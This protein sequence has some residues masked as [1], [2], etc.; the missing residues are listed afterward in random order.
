MPELSEDF[1]R[2]P[3]AHRG[4]HERSRGAVENSRAAVAAAVAAGYAIEIDVQ[5]ASCG[6]PMVF[7]D[8]EL[9]RLT[10]ARGRL[11]ARPAEELTEIALLD[12]GETIP[13]LAEILGLVNGRAPL[14]VE[15]KDQTGT[16]G[17][18]VGPLEERVAALLTGYDGPLAVMSFNPHSVDAM[19]RAAPQVA[20]GLTSCGFGGSEWRLSGARR[21]ELAALADY[22]RVGASFVSHDRRDLLNPA[23]RRLKERGV[24]VVAWT[25]RSPAEEA[26]ARRFADNVTFEGYKAP[27][28]D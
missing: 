22:D 9:L 14:L 3:I 4:L 21:T 20:R 28:P 1:L 5:R 13:T 23:L 18:E 26:A 12:G 25:I 17:P 11:D 19:R 2:S 8:D 6:Q 15:I 10:G 24:P 16:L 7:H 27:L